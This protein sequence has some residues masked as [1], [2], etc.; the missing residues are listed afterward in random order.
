[1]P[2]RPTCTQAGCGVRAIF[3]D[4]AVRSPVSLR[5]RPR[6]SCQPAARAD[7]ARVRVSLGPEIMRVT[8]K[9]MRVSTSDQR[10]TQRPPAA[11]NGN[12]FGPERHRHWRRGAGR[13]WRGLPRAWSTLAHAAAAPPPQTAVARTMRLSP[14]RRLVAAPC[15]CDP[16]CSHP[17]CAPVSARVGECSRPAMWERARALSA[18]HPLP[19]VVSARWGKAA[20]T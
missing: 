12:R 5:A 13:L 18:R 4:P 15:R 16:S 10:A 7:D 1:V 17:A 8:S 2:T 3:G 6:V 9:V 20:R 11:P 19:A 14:R